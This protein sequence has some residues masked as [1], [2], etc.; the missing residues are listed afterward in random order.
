MAVRLTKFK[1]ALYVFFVVCA[2]GSVLAF[3]FGGAGNTRGDDVVLPTITVWGN[4]D[5]KLAE[6][7]N[8]TAGNPAR[9]TYQQMRADTVYN[10][11]LESVAVNQAPDVIIMPFADLGKFFSTDKNFTIPYESYGERAYDDAFISGA[12]LLKS[13]TGVTAVPIFVDPLVMFYN[14]AMLDDAGMLAPMSAWSDA[15]IV[16]EAL[17]RRSGQLGITRSAF[18]I[19]EGSNVTHADSILSALFLQLGLRI[20]VPS[21]L[22]FTSDLTKSTNSGSAGASALR[23]YT[24]FADPSKNHYTWNRNLPQDKAAFLAE[25]LIYYFGLASE[26]RELLEKNPNMSLDVALLPQADG[27]QALTTGDLYVAIFPKASDSI[28]AGVAYAYWLV[29]PSTIQVL[30][31]AGLY[32]YTPPVRSVLAAPRSDRFSPVE[33]RSAAISKFWFDLSG[34]L[35]GGIMR[36]MISDVTAG[37]RSP[38]ES[39]GR[40]AARLDALQ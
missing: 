10:Q 7:I 24:S 2:I 9:V 32:P 23:F 1:I 19:G 13:A 22:Q 30:I 15:Y 3:R 5:M 17:T 16:S 12:S 20:M 36:D 28:P 31:D 21:E 38:E 29:N 37:R 40:G 39:I 35:S 26:R 34:Q 8:R 11:F 4:M 6:A 25:S 27:G 14:R 33:Y 18:G